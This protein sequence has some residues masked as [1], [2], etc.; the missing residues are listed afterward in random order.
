MKSSLCVR[1]T[2]VNTHGGR[3]AKCGNGE[4]ITMKR[5]RTIQNP[6]CWQNGNRISPQA[7][8]G[9][10]AGTKARE[11][12]TYTYSRF[13]QVLQKRG[14]MLG[15]HVYMEETLYLPPDTGVASVGSYHTQAHQK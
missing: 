2:V 4:A 11:I 13:N 14:R 7:Q 12:Y 10:D 8:Y 15:F 3:P 5:Q 1:H 9:T 6:G